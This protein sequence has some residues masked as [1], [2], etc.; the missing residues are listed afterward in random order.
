M[1]ALSSRRGDR[2]QKLDHADG[3]KKSVAV[4]SQ[5]LRKVEGLVSKA[6]AMLG[7]VNRMMKDNLSM[8]QDI[9]M[10]KAQKSAELELIEYRQKNGWNI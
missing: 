9:E 2:L 3:L 10:L 8:R 7:Q 1:S 5:S 6:D 4:T